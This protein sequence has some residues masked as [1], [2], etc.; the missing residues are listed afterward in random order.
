[1]GLIFIICIIL[2]IVISITSAPKRKKAKIET[3][4]ELAAT[5]KELEKNPDDVNLII[6]KATAIAYLEGFENGFK[7]LMTVA[8]L[9][10]RMAYNPSQRESS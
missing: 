8:I 1:M 10:S 9:L 3:E 6:K 7:I 5:L 2:I 4:S